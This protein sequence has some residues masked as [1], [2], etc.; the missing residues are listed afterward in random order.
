MSKTRP[1]RKTHSTPQ[2][3]ARPTSPGHYAAHPTVSGRWLL[4][5]LAIVLL[6]ALLCAWG[7]LCILFWQGSW[8]LLYHPTSAVTRTPASAN[9]PFESIGF[10]TTPSGESQLHGWWI[11]A[12]SSQARF[13]AI[14]LHGETGNL[15]DTVPALISLH[16]AGL[17]VFAFDYRGYGQSHFLHP[18]EARWREDAESALQYLTGTRH[19]PTASIVLIGRDLGANLALEVAA[20]QPDLAA[21]ILEQPLESPTAAIF[22]DPRAHLVPAHLLVRDRWQADA[23]ASNL[24]IPSLWFYWTPAG[25]AHDAD[26]PQVYRTVPAR[27]TIVWLTNS[28]DELRLFNSALSAFLDQLQP[29][30]R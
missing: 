15:G 7:T 29:P 28:P 30:A 3:A 21:V 16:N 5:G 24:L 4:S 1:S 26:T 23:A 18:S 17:N 25:T 10:N 2:S 20:A 19:I 13:T 11:P 12:A 8:Q 27:K 22:N 14:Y 9:L 6:A